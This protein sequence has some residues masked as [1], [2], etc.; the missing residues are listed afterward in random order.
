MKNECQHEKQGYRLP[1]LSGQRSAQREHQAAAC[2][3]VNDKWKNRHSAA[4]RTPDDADND[5]FE[6]KKRE[7]NVDDTS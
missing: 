3:S 4:T 5:Q 2:A 6:H 1:G 7:R